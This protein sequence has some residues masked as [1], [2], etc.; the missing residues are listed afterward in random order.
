MRWDS[1]AIVHDQ[2]YVYQTETTDI[3]SRQSIRKLIV[4]DKQGP[5]YFFTEEADTMNMFVLHTAHKARYVL[6][7]CSAEYLR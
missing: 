3:T 7:A 4:R 6:P 5:A 2:E 1:I